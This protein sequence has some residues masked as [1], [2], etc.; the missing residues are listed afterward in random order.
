MTDRTVLFVR[1]SLE[2]AETIRNEAELE[3]RTMSSYVLNIVLRSLYLEELLPSR[4]SPRELGIGSNN[5]RIRLPGPRTAVLIRC[6]VDEA[7]RI[8]AAAQRRET[9]ISGFILH[10]LRRSWNIKAAGAAFA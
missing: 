1:C 9:T 5:T 7:S 6:S 2:E 8:R 3:R 10:A 4:R